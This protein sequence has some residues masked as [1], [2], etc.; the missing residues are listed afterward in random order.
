MFYLARILNLFPTLVSFE[1]RVRFVVFFDVFFS[2]DFVTLS[3]QVLQVSTTNLN[4]CKTPRQN[5]KHVT[6]RQEQRK[7]RSTN[8]KHVNIDEQM[9][10][11]ATRSICF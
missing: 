8:P 10:K 6:R 2:R 5:E 9:Q 3:L 1:G 11:V 4:T 7:N